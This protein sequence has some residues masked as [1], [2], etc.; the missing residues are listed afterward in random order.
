VLL[1][2]YQLHLRVHFDN[3]LVFGCNVLFGLFS[4]FCLPLTKAWPSLIVASSPVSLSCCRIASFSPMSRASNSFASTHAA[5]S[6]LTRQ[7]VPVQT[8]PKP[9]RSAHYVN[10]PL[11]LPM[12]CWKADSASIASFRATKFVGECLPLN[13]QVRFLVTSCN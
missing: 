3:L 8:L 10:C 4:C 2:L 12:G 9:S 5:S 6:R 1:S 13:L 11:W 7:V